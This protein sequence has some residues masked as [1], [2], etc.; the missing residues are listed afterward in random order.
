MRFRHATTLAVLVIVAA[1]VLA[2]AVTGPAIAQPTRNSTCSSCHSGAA[3]G[4]V[5]ATPSTSTPAAGASYTVAINIGLT[6]SGDTGYHIA[7]TD[8]A[9]TATN[10]IAAYSGMSPQTSW[11]AT[12]T[13]PAAAGSYYYKVWCAKGPDNSSGM[14]KVAT[15]SITVA[16]PAA[17]AAI[18]SLTPNHAQAGAGV[19]IAG[20][21]LGSGGAVRFGSTVAATTAWSATSVT[22]TVPASLAAGATSVTVTP[23]GGSASNAVAFTVDA[24]PAPS[25]SIAPTTTAGGATADTWCNDSVH[26]TLTATDDAGGSGVASITYAVDGGAPKTV[27]GA[28]V[29]VAI[30]EHPEG[31]TN[32]AARAMQGPHTITYYA[33]DAAG[34]VETAHVLTVNIDTMKPAT[35]APR[36]AKVRR[37]HVATLKYEVRDT[38]PNSGTATVVIT[39]KNSRGKVVKT[40]RLGARPVNRALAASFKCTLRAGT[41]RFFVRATDAAGNTQA[42]IAKQT[43]RVRQAN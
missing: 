15:Y 35:K 20:A 32:A 37:H 30:G 16:P 31:I 5:T 10:W 7:S 24:P 43:L 33:T 36:A 25:D 12:M 21:N 40:L 4:A 14:G 38:T 3:S 2:A 11:T 8:A 34:N 13:A 6:A 1:A 9:G 26:V 22:A 29:R 39:V 41:Y 23:A 42:N 18:T 17:T 27:A 28:S 19:V